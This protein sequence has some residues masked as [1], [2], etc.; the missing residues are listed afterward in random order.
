MKKVLLTI[1][2]VLV[3]NGV[4]AG[5]G[6]AGYRIGYFQGIQVTSDGTAPSFGRDRMPQ[7]HPGLYDRGFD[8]GI[9][10]SHFFIMQRGRGF[11]FFSPFQFLWRIALLGL[12]VWLG[13][14]LFRRSG[15]QLSVNRQQT[16]NPKADSIIPDEEK[17][18]SG[19]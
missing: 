1:L 11:G 15:W 10:P 18:K 13:Y 16:G 7:F 19:E 4:L 12:V 6:F 5:A 14:M 9:A 2:A 3:A 17:P 8:R